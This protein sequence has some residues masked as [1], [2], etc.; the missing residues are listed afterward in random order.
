[1]AF[2][3]SKL[4]IVK[5]I[6]KVNFTDY[7]GLFIAPP[8]FG[9]TTTASHF[10]NSVIVP[11]ENG[12]DGVVA[13]VVQGI[14]KWADFINFVNELE[15]NREEIG[16]SIE[17]IVF[18][19]VNK[20]YEMSEDYTLAL[21]SRGSKVRYRKPSDVPHGAFYSERDK[22]FSKQIERILDLGFSI[23]FITHSKV[24]T[25]RPKKAEPYDVY[26]STMPERLSNIINPLVS[27]ILYGEKRDI[28]GVQKR[29][30]I[31]SG[32][33]M[34][35]AGS[36]VHV[37]EDIVFDDEKEAMERYQEL[38]KMEVQERLK[39]SGITRDLDEIA[40]EQKEQ[41]IEKAKEYI[42]KTKELDLIGQIN[43]KVSALNEEQVKE[44]KVALK[45]EFNAISYKRFS[46][47]KYPKVLEIVTALS[48]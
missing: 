28:E 46:E 13:N 42:E 30:L 12:V 19:T 29:V 31:T 43:E 40:K 24:K 35:D 44:F 10:P 34:A 39:E 36:R 48:K 14:S 26:S 8:K 22:L 17:T 45:K 47:D 37:K 16:D 9:K 38:F 5:N 33:S 1:M 27:F 21:L 41:K 32:T 20:A 4:G 23:L 15:D 11:F 2:D 18:D 25:I 3:L 6:P 7:T